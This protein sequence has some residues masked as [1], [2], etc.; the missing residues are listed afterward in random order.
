VPRVL[1][2]C[3]CM[4][5]RSCVSG[6]VSV[7]VCLCARSRT[8]VAG[9]VHD[10]VFFLSCLCYEPQA[11]E[12]VMRRIQ[13]KYVWERG[14]GFDDPENT[15][16]G[17]EEDVES[18]DDPCEPVVQR[19]GL[20][21]PD[22]MSVDVDAINVN[23]KTA[24]YLAAAAGKTATVRMLLVC[25]VDHTVLTKRRKNALYAAVEAG[26]FVQLRSRIHHGST[27]PSR[28]IVFTVCHA[29]SVLGKLEVVKVLLSRCTPDD[30]NVITNFGTSAMHI[31][32]KSG[33]N[34][35]LGASHRVGH[36]PHAL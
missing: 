27:L 29:L 13:P 4:C 7:S 9:I 32:S 10:G 33:D 8:C 14:D 20:Q 16:D 31:A 28:F 21:H 3:L 2:V 12:T 6:P 30:V 15:T 1:C 11:V 17:M 26:M 22:G 35:M 18:D 19:G 36:V 24:L 23:S 34:K 25:N 5:V